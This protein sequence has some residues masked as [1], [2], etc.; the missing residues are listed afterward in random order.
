ML[1]AARNTLLD[2]MKMS[3]EGGYALRLDC[4]GHRTTP[5]DAATS[6]ASAGAIAG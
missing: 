6:A 2:C 4:G 1:A 5:A 3:G